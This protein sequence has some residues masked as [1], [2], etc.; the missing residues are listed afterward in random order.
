M[1]LEHRVK[2]TAVAATSYPYPTCKPLL[3]GLDALVGNLGVECPLHRMANSRQMERG[4]AGANAGIS[5]CRLK[6]VS[7]EI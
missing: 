5:S 4:G 3:L 2:L 1:S 6:Q 7:V